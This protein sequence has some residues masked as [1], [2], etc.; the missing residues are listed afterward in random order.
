MYI[1]TPYPNVAY[2]D[3]AAGFPAVEVPAGN[4]QAAVGEAVATS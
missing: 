2:V 1:V 3:H 4:A